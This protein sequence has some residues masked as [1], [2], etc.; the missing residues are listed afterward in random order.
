MQKCNKTVIVKV[1]KCQHA[2]QKQIPEFP[3][4]TNI[5]MTKMPQNA[6]HATIPKMHNATKM[7]MKTTMTKC[8]TPKMHNNVHIQKDNK[9]TRFPKCPTM[10]RSQNAKCNKCQQINNA[11]MTNCHSNKL[12][13]KQKYEIW[14]N[15]KSLK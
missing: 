7:K 9:N 15:A 5:K 3:T 1:P 2:E 11:N 13:T 6:K 8:Q 12:P 10:P 4:C 14:E